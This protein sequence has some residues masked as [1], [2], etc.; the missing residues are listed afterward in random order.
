MGVHSETMFFQSIY[1]LISFLRDI[2]P[3][4]VTTS[5]MDFKSFFRI[6]VI[7][8]QAYVWIIVR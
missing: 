8:I 2:Y 4:N 1:N 7:V 3:H 5:S 6:N